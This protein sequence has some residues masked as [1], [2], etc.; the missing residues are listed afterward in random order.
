MPEIRALTRQKPVDTTIDLG[1]GETIQLTFDAN[2]VTPRWVAE[3][4]RRVNDRDTLSLPKALAEAIIA[5]DVTDD[6][7]PFEPSADNI[8]RLSFP[9]MGLFFERIMEAAVP[10]VAEGNASSLSASEPRLA[11][12]EETLPSSLNGSDT[13]TSPQ[14]SASL[15][16]S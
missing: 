6:G 11:T 2:M 13:L 1:D 10:G 9:A 15:S 16:L 4:E 12:S 5:W 8:S 7:Q 3:T 14:G